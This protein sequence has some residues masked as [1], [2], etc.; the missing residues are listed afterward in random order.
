M[1]IPLNEPVTV[2]P[3]EQ[4]VFDEFWLADFRIMAFDPNKPVKVVA[5]IEKARTLE[6][7]AKELMPNGSHNYVEVDF[8]KNATEEDLQIMGALLLRI[9]AKA[10][11]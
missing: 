6:G 9:K 8:F 10:G 5:R 2:P 11:I 7:G 4:K 3:T 1:A